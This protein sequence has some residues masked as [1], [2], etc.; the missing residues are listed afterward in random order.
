MGIRRDNGTGLYSTADEYADDGT[1]IQMGSFAQTLS[2]SSGV[3]QYI[4]VT[5]DGNTYRKTFTYT[6]TDLTGISV[7]VKQ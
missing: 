4:E 5:V 6:G 2:Y 3:L 1:L 7:W